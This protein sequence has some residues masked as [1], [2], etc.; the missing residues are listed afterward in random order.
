ML[1]DDA[2][3]HP[4]LQPCITRRLSSNNQSALIAAPLP[5]HKTSNPQSHASLRTSEA[6]TPV[7]APPITITVGQ[8]TDTAPRTAASHSPHPA[9][10][11]GAGPSARANG[12]LADNVAP[13]EEEEGNDSD[14]YS[15]SQRLGKM[16]IHSE[17]ASVSAGDEVEMVEDSMDTSNGMNNNFSHHRRHTTAETSQGDLEAG[18]FSLPPLSSATK[19]KLP[20][21]AFS[22][23]SSI[24]SQDPALVSVSSSALGSEIHRFSPELPIRPL[25]ASLAVPPTNGHVSPT[26]SGMVE[27]TDKTPTKA[28]PTAHR[29]PSPTSSLSELSDLSEDSE[30]EDA[31]GSSAPEPAR[32]PSAVFSGSTR[33]RG[34]S[35]LNNATTRKVSSSRRRSTRSTKNHVASY[36]DSESEEDP[37]HSSSFNK[38]PT[39]RARKQR[40]LSGRD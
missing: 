8:T 14:T 12:G 24:V 3:K 38:K 2:L 30:E 29:A 31:A 5:P 18:S 1:A 28:N 33:G 25:P 17:A 9:A 15:Y 7:R 11:N 10:L 13:G 6:T 16:T 27:N 23:D 35:K 32:R 37:D 36:A 22:S 4:W 39:G 40:K 26:A 20:P 21:S 34:G 19:R